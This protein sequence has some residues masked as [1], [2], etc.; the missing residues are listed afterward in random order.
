M[1]ITIKEILNNLSILNPIIVSSEDSK[2]AKYY[3]VP[4]YRNG[5]IFICGWNNT[6][7]MDRSEITLLN[8]S[9][10]INQ[11]KN[12]AKLIKRERGTIDIETVRLLKELLY[13]SLIDNYDD[14]VRYSSYLNFLGKQ[15]I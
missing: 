4:I 12:N 1:Y 3:F 8:P 11:E 10:L 5:K 13:D 9:N 7:L 2:N 6:R 15:Q 14:L